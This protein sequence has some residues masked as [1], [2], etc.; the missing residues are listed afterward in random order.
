MLD[1]LRP[2]NW[3]K[4]ATQSER[5]INDE[6]SNDE[7]YGTAQTKNVFFKYMNL[8]IFKIDLQLTTKFSSYKI[9]WKW[10]QYNLESS[11]GE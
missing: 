7:K 8:I 10:N 4:F 3:K 9:V 11:V 6:R 5:L 2:K 1:P